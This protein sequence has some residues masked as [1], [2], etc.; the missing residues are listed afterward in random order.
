MLKR[1]YQK[2]IFFKWEK[3]MSYPLKS[4][5]LQHKVSEINGSAVKV[6]LNSVRAVSSEVFKPCR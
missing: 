3:E 4:M 2:S 6:T 5:N 1:N